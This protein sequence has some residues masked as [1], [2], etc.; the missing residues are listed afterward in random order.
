MTETGSQAPSQPGDARRPLNGRL[1]LFDGS[2]WRY[3][4]TYCRDKRSRL[5]FYIVVT[6]IQSMLVLPVLYLVRYTF[7]SA[8]P[9]GN[10]RM[11]FVFGA[12]IL[13]VRLA[14]SLVSLRMR[15]FVLRINTDVVHAM[16]RDLVVKLYDLSHDFHT[17]MNKDAIHTQIVQDTSRVDVMGNALLSNILP[18]L[19]TSGALLVV[20]CALNWRLVLAAA[21]IV[22]LVWIAAH[23]TGRF[24]KREVYAFQRAFEVFSGGVLFVL[25]HMNLTRVQGYEAEESERQAGHIR[26]LRDKSVRM[27]MSYAV[28]NQV[29]QNV[30][31]V[32]GL[33]ILVLGGA[34]IAQGRMS[35]GEFM[36]FYVAAGLLNGSVSSALGGL[37][38]VI[39]G[40]ASLVSLRALMSS[41]DVS[42][43]AGRRQIGFRG[44]IELRRV[45]FQYGD[46]RLLDDVSLTIRPG[47][48]LAV[49]GPNGTGKSTLVG[50]ILGF[51]KPGLGGV[52]AD[53]IAY[54]ELDLRQLR[55][56]IGVVPQH[57]T[58]FSGT[59]FENIAYG[60]PDASRADVTTAARLAL[61]DEF[62]QSLPKG[63]DTQV[64]DDGVRLSGGECQRLAL[65]RA[66]LAQP[67]VLILDEPTNH[68]DA[69]SVERL[70]AGLIAW[71]D[72]PAI[73]TISHDSHV[74]SYV[75][76]VYRLSDGRL[77]SPLAQRCAS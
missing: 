50:L 42:P 60:T 52:Y 36:S 55:R 11:L 24:V 49:V 32:A 19:V 59:V 40:N 20:L 54:D 27:A 68:L 57:P 4:Y 65:A 61:A 53:G 72:R 33:V 22:P 69:E 70:M 26:D 66:L 25:K 39:A 30:S 16:R 7:D 6:S 44:N 8:I 1:A 74:L 63:Y 58:F 18:A 2:A 29:Q 43:Y 76:D 15:A 14:N 75:D 28:H 71:P 12:G 56:S 31:G 38:E 23:V 64:G 35:L 17:R 13:A 77:L 10:V 41:D 37:P 48:N 34:A 9:R 45:A 21:A 67:R 5:A 62:V 51:N 3:F 73:V 46:A 47:A